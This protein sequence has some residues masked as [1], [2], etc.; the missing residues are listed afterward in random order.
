MFCHLSCPRVCVWKRKPWASIRETSLKFL[1]IVRYIILS[2]VMSVCVCV[3]KRM[4]WANI[5]VTSRKL[6]TI[7]RHIILWSVMS[8]CVCVCVKRMPWASIRVT[9]LKLFT[10]VRHI[11]LSSV[12]SVCVQKNAYQCNIS[13]PSHKCQLYYSVTCHV[14]VTIIVPPEMPPMWGIVW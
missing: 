9:F 1:I 11:I 3:W 4:P 7:V 13:G 6:L 12:M 2:F 14:R 10:I 5:R 8:V